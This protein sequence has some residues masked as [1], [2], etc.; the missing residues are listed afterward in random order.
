MANE[1][2]E[3]KHPQI[4]PQENTLV[5]PYGDSDDPFTLLLRPDVQGGEFVKPGCP[6][7]NSKNRQQ[8][9]KFFEDHQQVTKIKAWMDGE[10]EFV[11]LSKLYLHFREHYAS[12]ER[13]AFMLEYRDKIAELMKRRKD[14]A[15][16]IEYSVN[17]C[18]VEVSK[19]ISLP[20]D[21]LDQEQKKNDML[22]KTLKSFR[23]GVAQ[24][25]DMEDGG[26]HTMAI[27]DR[28]IN[29]FNIHLKNAKTDEEKKVLVSTLEGLKTD[30]A[31]EGEFKNA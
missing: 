12:Q 14:R 1:I 19:I 17:V 26:R 31:M 10:K 7:C 6:I 15:R 11:A 29:V 24:L 18:L 8:I 30:L 28:I 21:G 3:E 25:N 9:E 23:D 5:P 2:V 20:T 16:D 22:V 4:H 27:Q 13:L